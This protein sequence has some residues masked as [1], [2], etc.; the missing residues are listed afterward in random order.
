ML[1]SRLFL[2]FQRRKRERSR[3]AF[4]DSQNGAHEREREIEGDVFITGR[5][6]A[7][8]ASVLVFWT[9]EDLLE[10]EARDWD[11]TLRQR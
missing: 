9:F 5:Q 1:N 7:K 2:P 6:S 4:R 11:R 10:S 8:S 3:E